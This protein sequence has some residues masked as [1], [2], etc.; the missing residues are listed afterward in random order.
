MIES[1]IILQLSHARV[2]VAPNVD[3]LILIY[4]PRKAFLCDFLGNVKVRVSGHKFSIL[5]MVRA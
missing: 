2:G 1:I 4:I 5:F 3:T